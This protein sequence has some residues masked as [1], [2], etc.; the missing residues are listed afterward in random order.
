MIDDQAERFNARGRGVRSYEWEAMFSSVYHGNSRKTFVGY[1]FVDCTSDFI[2]DT[3]LTI[4]AT[5]GRLKAT[6]LR[7][8]G[9]NIAVTHISPCS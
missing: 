9:V 5:N 7:D 4:T 6:L 8:I 1:D 2:P 3:L